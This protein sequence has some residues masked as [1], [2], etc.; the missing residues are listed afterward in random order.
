MIDQQANLTENK[1]EN[2]GPTPAEVR[3]RILA[4]QLSGDY[5]MLEH[6]YLAKKLNRTGGAITHALDGDSPKL[7]ARIVRHLD[8]LQR[9]R[10]KKAA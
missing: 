7:L 5:P 1:A 3:L 10:E 9:T 8:W 2:Q 4:M 6:R